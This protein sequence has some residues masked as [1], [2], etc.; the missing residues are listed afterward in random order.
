MI[1]G[2]KNVV[3]F[4]SV[5]ISTVFTNITEI[6]TNT[7]HAQKM[8]ENLTKLNMWAFEICFLKRLDVIHAIK[9]NHCQRVFSQI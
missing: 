5:K 2:L 8:K 4:K 7:I 1:D 6:N 3:I 9:L